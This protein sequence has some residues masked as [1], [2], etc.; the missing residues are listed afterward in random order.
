MRK[1]NVL[2]LAA[3]L[4]LTGCGE[5]GVPQTGNG[6]TTEQTKEDN[7]PL[8]NERIPQENEEIPENK[9]AEPE[10][11][12]GAWRV[13]YAAF[14]AEKAA[15]EAWVR[16]PENPE[17][18]PNWVEAEAAEAIGRYFLYDIDKN[19]V[20]ELLMRYG[21]GEA[22]Y[23]TT[24]YGYVNGAVTDLGDVASGHAAFYTWPGENAVALNWGHMG[25]NLITR[26]SLAD[27]KLTEELVFEEFIDGP[28]DAYT[29]VAEIVPG[30]LQL[31]EA[32]PTA[33]LPEYGALVLPVYH[34]GT[35]GTSRPLDPRRDEEAKAEIE[36]VL[37]GGGEFYGVTADGFDGDTGWITMEAYLTPGGVT[38]YA[39]SSLTV[40]KREW[41]DFNGDGQ[42]E[43]LV[44]IEHAKGD[45]Y[46][47][48]MQVVF[49]LEED[50][51]VYAYCMNYMNGYE[52]AGTVFVSKYDR[53]ETTIAFDLEQAYLYTPGQELP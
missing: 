9:S 47:G 48:T 51:V 18:D 23:Y 15:E 34:Y 50:G 12:D 29:A 39:E 35:E 10:E 2:V 43:A 5:R 8:D 33:A 53:T 49:S 20:P 13:T 32:R 25:G 26:I 38:E 21:A 31:Q 40:T 36:H 28:E 6:E 22:G 11:A 52:P 7:I 3:C 24:V 30:A 44:T 14:L 27:G 19:G 4:L 45:P 37:T 46:G 17:Y 16:N 42:S 1:W 41:L